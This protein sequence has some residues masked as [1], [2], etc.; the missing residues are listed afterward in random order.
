MGWVDRS[1]DLMRPVTSAATYINYL[2]SGAPV[3]VENSYGENY[4]RLQTLKEALDPENVFHLNRNIRPQAHRADSDGVAK[5]G[6]S[7]HE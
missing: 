3:D 6:G 2:S 4:G 1:L 5:Y 7:R